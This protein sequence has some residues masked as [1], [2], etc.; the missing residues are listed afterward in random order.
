MLYISQSV[1]LDALQRATNDH[2]WQAC[3]N[4]S[5]LKADFHL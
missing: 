3:T 5:L 4:Y 1:G 2:Y